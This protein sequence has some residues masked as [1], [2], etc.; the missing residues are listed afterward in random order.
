MT[1]AAISDERTIPPKHAPQLPVVN[2]P[3]EGQPVVT[4]SLSR[5][6]RKPLSFYMT[7]LCLGLLA[8]IVSWDATALSVAVPVIAEQLQA[9]TLEAFF[10]SIAF[11]LAVAI[12]QPLY[13]AISDAIGRKIPL[14]AGMA[15]FTLGSILFAVAQNITTAI[16]GRLIQGLGG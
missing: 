15:L 6:G 10:A 2:Q 1:V 12:S 5:E 9:T 8:L 3:E 7:L 13:L 14:Y 16:A 4:A 11:T